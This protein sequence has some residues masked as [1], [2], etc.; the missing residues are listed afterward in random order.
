MKFCDM[1]ILRFA[2]SFLP[3]NYVSVVFEMVAIGYISSNTK[4]NTWRKVFF[5]AVFK[6]K[7]L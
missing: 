7:F 1:V 3:P 5:Q 2:I 6:V 4:A